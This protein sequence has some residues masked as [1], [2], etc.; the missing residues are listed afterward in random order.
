MRAPKLHS[1]RNEDQRP[2]YVLLAV[3][4][5]IV[6]L[7]LAAYRY[8]DMTNSESKATQNI[9]QN[10]QAKALADSGI[11]YA[12]GLLSDPNAYANTLGGNPFN[13]PGA[14]QNQAVDLGNGKTGYFSI[15]CLDYT[16]VG[17]TSLPLIYGVIDESSRINPNALMQIDTTGTVAYNMLTSQSTQAGLNMP[18][19]LANSILDWIDSDSTPRT[20]GAETSTYEEFMPTSYQCKNAPLDSVEEMLL[21]NG[22][23][24]LQFYGPDLNRN[25]YLDGNESTLSTTYTPGY[26]P[27]L[28]VYSRSTN[29]SSLGT[30][31]IYINGNNLQTVYTQLNGVVSQEMAAYVVAYRALSPPPPN[32]KA[33]TAT[34]NAAA[35]LVQTMLNGN[36]P[37]RA[38]RAIASIYQLIG[39]SVL[40]PGGRGGGTIFPCPISGPNAAGTD[41]PALADQATTVNSMYL[42]ARINVNTAS[43]T[44]LNGLPGLTTDD[45]NN[46]LSARPPVGSS[47]AA[48]PTFSNTAWLYTTANI[49]AIKMIALERYITAQ[50]QVYRIQAFGYFEKGGPVARVEAVVDTNGG[51]P[52]ILYYR[53]L[54]DLGRAIDPRTLNNGNSNGN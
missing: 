44:V 3:L 17:N 18:D 29:V 11:Y 45:V 50:T 13:N 22:M 9:L 48:D 5:V 25:G 52:R 33:A 6:V 43:P 30:P 49:S 16:Q 14:F 12:M 40:I 35:S 38:Q 4:I 46:I 54:T 53:D 21:V 24:P 27:F 1:V 31:R 47:G 34:G 10:A 41:L 8:S 2:G 7:S 42:P 19:E 37:P 39:T 15:M 32:S 51:Q 20:G 26:A 36:S 23:T 28:T